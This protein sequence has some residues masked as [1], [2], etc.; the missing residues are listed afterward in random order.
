MSEQR[1]PRGGIAIEMELEG[2]DLLEIAVPF[3]MEEL[4]RELTSVV[5]LA[6]AAAIK[7]MQGNHPYTDRTFLLTSG[8]RLQR[9]G[10]MT[11]TRAQAIVT[12]DAPYANLVNDGTW[13]SKA[14]PFMPQ[15]ERAAE[16]ELVI[17]GFDALTSFIRTL[18]MGR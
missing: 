6:G 15:G 5:D 17:R 13:K 4:G 1:S 10:R 16:R 7:E 8:M 12:F 3:A 14:Y 9:F 11:R 18:G 2:V